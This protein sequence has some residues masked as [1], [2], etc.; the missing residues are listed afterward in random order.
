MM[1]VRSTLLTEN[2]V[3]R[4]A[5]RVIAVASLRAWLPPP[6]SYYPREVGSQGVAGMLL[7]L[8]RNVELCLYLYLFTA[9]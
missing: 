9:C 1:Y 4:R 2:R 7:L 5:L 6:G 3:W 8:Q